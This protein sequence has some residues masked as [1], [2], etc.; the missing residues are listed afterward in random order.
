LKWAITQ[1]QQRIYLPA[2]C[3]THN[4]DVLLLEAGLAEALHRETMLRNIFAALA[5]SWGPEL[6]YLSKAPEPKVAD[7]LYREIYRVYDWVIEHTI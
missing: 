6:R 7:K 1:R 5:D 3:E 4:L 2:Q